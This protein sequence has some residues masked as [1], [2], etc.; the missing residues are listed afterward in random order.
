MKKNQKAFSLIE[1]IFVIAIM[2]IMVSLLM[3]AVQ[4][5]L[6]SKN[7]KTAKGF[8]TL[9]KNVAES[10]DVTSMDLTIPLEQVEDLSKTNKVAVTNTVSTNEL[11]YRSEFVYV[12]PTNSS[13]YKFCIPKAFTNVAYISIDGNNTQSLIRIEYRK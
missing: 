4:K 12:I 5:V 6:H 10:D 9:T 13:V 1:L 3:G 7:Y 11:I 8:Y 2:V